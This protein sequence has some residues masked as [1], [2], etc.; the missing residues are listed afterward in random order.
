MY[1][2]PRL[3]NKNYLTALF[4]VVVQF[5]LQTMPLCSLKCM[6]SAQSGGFLSHVV[7]LEVLEKQKVY[8]RYRAPYI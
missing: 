7:S 6:A 4:Q 2:I 3:F 5:S 1:A 8:Q